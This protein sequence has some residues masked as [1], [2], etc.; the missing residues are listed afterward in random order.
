M[1]PSE[2]QGEKI[3]EYSNNLS[4]PVEGEN[5]LYLVSQNGDI[6]TFKE[7]QLKAEFSFQGQTSSIAIDSEG[8]NFYLADQ[9][10]QAIIL[11]SLNEQGEA[12]VLDLV[13]EYEGQPL[14][15]PHSLTISESLNCLFFTDS[16]PFGETSI[17]NPKGSVFMIDLDD[18]I[19]RPLALNSLAFPSGLALS[20]DEKI[21]YVCETCKNRVLRFVLTS[22]GIYYSSVF[23]TFS[24]RFGPLACTVSTSDLLY[25]ARFEFG[26]LSDTGIIHVLTPG[27]QTKQIISLPNSP[28]ITGLCFS[29]IR[30]S[31]L[32]VTE[33]STQPQCLRVSVQQE[34]EQENQKLNINDDKQ[35]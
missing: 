28:E 33:N 32:Y 12:T 25:V 18:S 10:H 21:L 30:T 19:I 26:T 3:C 14:L 7:G 17:E 1:N 34:E 31:I 24:G 20:V 35:E 9:A 29:S 2:A 16:G 23:K 27:G 5:G 22:Q 13:K 6:L 8:K 11:R 4:S 15:G